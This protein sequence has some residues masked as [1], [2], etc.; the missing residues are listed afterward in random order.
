MGGT[1]FGSRRLRITVAQSRLHGVG[2]GLAGARRFGRTVFVDSPVGTRT[3]RGFGSAVRGDRTL[4][5]AAILTEALYAGLAVQRA[6]LISAPAYYDSYARSF[7]ATAGLDAEGT[8]VM[9]TLLYDAIDVDVHEIS[10]PRCAPYL[11]QP[12]LFIHSTD[13][14]VIAI[15]DS[16]DS[17]TAWPGASHLCVEGLGHWRI[18]VNPAVVAAAIEFVG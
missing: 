2:N 12:A 7:A 15:E 4:N 10:V 5:G 18:L 6:V 17:A 14:R 16:L 3:A 1:G 11:H 13:D 8:E 9:L